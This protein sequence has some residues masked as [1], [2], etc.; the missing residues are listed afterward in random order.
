MT[1]RKLLEQLQDLPPDLDVMALVRTTDQK[2][3]APL[4]AVTTGFVSPPEHVGDQ[5]EVTT[6]DE[7]ECDAAEKEPYPGDNCC[8]LYLLQ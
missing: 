2:E 7:W 8:A 3:A 4:H 6:Q 5:Y 1:V